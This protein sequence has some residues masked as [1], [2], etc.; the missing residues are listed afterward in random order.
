MKLPDNL[1]EDIINI[2]ASSFENTFI[3]E[4]LINQAKQGN[5][6]MMPNRS[7]DAIPVYKNGIFLFG[8]SLNSRYFMI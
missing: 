3:K 6:K 4:E 8:D 1:A 5:I 7:I 2:V